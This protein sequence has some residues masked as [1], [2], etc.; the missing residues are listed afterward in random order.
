M[1]GSLQDIKQLSVRPAAAER[2]IIFADSLLHLGTSVAKLAETY[3]LDVGKGEHP[4][5]FDP[6]AHGFMLYRRMPPLET[7]LWKQRVDIAFRTDHFI[8][9]DRH[10]GAWCGGTEAFERVFEDYV[11]SSGPAKRAKD[12]GAFAER[13]AAAH[14]EAHGTTLPPAPTTLKVRSPAIIFYSRGPFSPSLCH[15]TLRP[16]RR[17]TRPRMRPAQCGRL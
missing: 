11:R 7:F 1:V 14:L 17:A 3:E 13:L 10:S 4:V 15:P 5:F 8:E 16:S 12:Y 9:A 6:S 2:D